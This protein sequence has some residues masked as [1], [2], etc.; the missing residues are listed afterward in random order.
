M[1]D[2]LFAIMSNHDRGKFKVYKTFD[3][4]TTCREFAQMLR[5]SDYDNQFDIFVYEMKRLPG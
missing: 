4:V 2:R 1:N 5:D 3:D